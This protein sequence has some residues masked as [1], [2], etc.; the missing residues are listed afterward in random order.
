MNKK[1]TI[2]AIE[3]K[4]WKACSDFIRNRDSLSQ[5]VSGYCI[6]CDEFCEG[7]KAHAG[8]FLPNKACGLIT[9]Y[10]PNNIHLQCVKCNVPMSRSQ[11][12]KVKVY[13]SAKMFKLYGAK[14]VNELIKLSEIKIK[15]TK[16]FYE[17]LTKLYICADTKKI[18]DF[19]KRHCYSTE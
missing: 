3:K 6:S 1:P 13:Y 2:K 5:G 17:E 16:E 18:L 7:K 8:H 4:L 15:P 19:L 10:H 9:R 11:T 12:E 14:K